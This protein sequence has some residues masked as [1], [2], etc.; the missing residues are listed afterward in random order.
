MRYHLKFPYWTGDIRLS[1]HFSS[2]PIEASVCHADFNVCLLLHQSRP[3]E[4]V[5]CVYEVAFC[6]VLCIV[7]RPMARQ[8]VI[9]SANVLRLVNMKL[10]RTLLREDGIGKEDESFACFLV[11]IIVNKYYHRL[12]TDTV[13]TLT[14]NYDASDNNDEHLTAS[15]CDTASSRRGDESSESEFQPCLLIRSV[16]SKVSSLCLMITH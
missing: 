4:M 16:Q 10:R 2:C 15:G 12:E 1:V 11:S 9:N 13:V 8:L 5:Q 3:V 6:E 7:K 14:H